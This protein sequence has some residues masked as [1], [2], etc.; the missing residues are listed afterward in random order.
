MFLHWR[1][2][3]TAHS[4]KT[5]SWTYEGA[6][7]ARLVG[8]EQ[9]HTASPGNSKWRVTR[10]VGSSHHIDGKV[11]GATEAYHTFP[12]GFVLFPGDIV[13]H[14]TQ[15]VTEGSDIYTLEPARQQ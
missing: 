8:V 6:A 14:T 1:T 7:P 5:S 13:T 3:T 11:Y 10:S 12:P 9:A 2:I 4:D 15:N